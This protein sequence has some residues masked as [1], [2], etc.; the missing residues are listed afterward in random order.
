MTTTFR[1]IVLDVPPTPLGL[2]PA[3]VVIEHWCN[4]CRAK[5]ASADL[6][7]HARS[8]DARSPVPHQGGAID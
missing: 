4:A 2:L 8:H 6:A 7:R 1:T 3:R 5:V